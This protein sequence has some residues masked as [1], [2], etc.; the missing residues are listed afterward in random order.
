MRRLGRWS[1]TVVCVSDAKSKALNSGGTDNAPLETEQ[2]LSN[3]QD[4]LGRGEEEDEQEARHDDESAEQDPP[5]AVGGDEPAVEDRSQDGAT[6]W[7]VGQ[8]FG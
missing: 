1:R 4:S 3:E 5:W 2:E 8:R 6:T 7:T